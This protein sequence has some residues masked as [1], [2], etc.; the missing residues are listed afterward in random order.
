MIL[1]PEYKQGNDKQITPDQNKQKISHLSQKSVIYTL[2]NSDVYGLQIWLPNT[3]STTGMHLLSTLPKYY[4]F[5]TI[6]I[7]L[8][9]PQY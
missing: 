3:I 1:L 6:Q 9:A 2:Y 5:I 7:P 8:K 4:Y